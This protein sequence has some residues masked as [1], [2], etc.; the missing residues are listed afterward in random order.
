MWIELGCGQG[1][2]PW[3]A[4][5]YDEILR[6]GAFPGMQGLDGRWEATPDKHQGST[7]SM[8]NPH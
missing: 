8:H 1:R 6:S 7:C 2:C 4:N 3:V 5:G